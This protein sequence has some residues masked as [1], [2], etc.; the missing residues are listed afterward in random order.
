MHRI[1]FYIFYIFL[2]SFFSQTAFA[3]LN[4]ELTQGF[5]G[6]VPIAVVPFAMTG[7][8]PSQ[9]I[10]AIVA[11]DLRNSGRFKVL[12][13]DRLTKFPSDVS[14]V[15]FD[16]FHKLGVDN[17]V[18]GRVQQVGGR[19]EVKVQL[20]DA[21]KL[22][23]E[24]N[25]ASMKQGAIGFDR[26]FF[27][28]EE[29]LRALAHHISDEIYQHITGVRGIFSTKLAYVVVQKEQKN[30]GESVKYVLEVADQDGYQPKPLLISA[31]PIMSPAWSP[32]GNKVA[33]VSFEHKH[34]AIYIED[35]ATG[36]RTLAS[37]FPGINGAPAWSPDGQKLAL[38]LSKSGAPNI[39]ILE[40]KSHRLTQLTQDF[41]INTEPAWSPDGQSLIFTSNRSG[42]PQIYL[43]NLKT[44]SVSRVTYEGKY[45]ARSAF[46]PDGN[47]IIVL[48]QD[49]GLFN[50]GILDLDSGVLRTLTHSGSD[51]ES[52]SIA[53]NGSMVLFGAL[54]KG[55]SVLG[56][57]AV[58]GSVQ[59]RLPSR[60]GNVQDPAWSPFLS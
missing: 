48:N 34:A 7:G 15:Q 38:V 50:I 14:Q 17:I 31:E 60:N 22:N 25:Q 53:P 49:S 19:F 3:I 35:V 46:T 58:D 52:P 41:Y 8:A 43:M 33:Y 32:N 54:Y 42:S 1:F 55:K 51:N 36:A 56:M 44:R 16:Y 24:Q 2:F 47:H 39:Y 40:L 45:N 29:N 10:S 9:D 26:T 27:S 6:A 59:I 20:L 57:A 28:S 13:A 18:V 4:M 5:S 30:P 12:G 11:N 23:K 21:M 37:E